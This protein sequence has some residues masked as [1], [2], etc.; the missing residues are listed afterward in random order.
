MP[1]IGPFL[2]YDLWGLAPQVRAGMENSL[3]TC[4]GPDLSH[5]VPLSGQVGVSQTMETTKDILPPGEVYGG[6]VVLSCPIA[7]TGHLLWG[8]F[9]DQR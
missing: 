5:A 1:G 9:G 6:G 3:V 2:P 4:L 8:E 7:T